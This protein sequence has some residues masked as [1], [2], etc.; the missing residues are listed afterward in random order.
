[1]KDNQI[2]NKLEVDIM[3]VLTRT[4]GTYHSQFKIYN[5]LVED[6]D[7]KDPV[8]KDNLKTKILTILRVLPHTFNNIKVIK[9][10]NIL[11][12]AFSPEKEIITNEIINEKNEELIIDNKWLSE[13]AVINFIIDE[14]MD[15]YIYKKDYTGNTVLHSLILSNDE[16]RIKKSFNKLKNM[17]YEKNLDKQTP[18]EVIN[19]FKVSNFFINY[20]FKEYDLLNKNFNVTKII[21]ERLENHLLRLY[22]ITFFLFC[23]LLFESLLIYNLILKNK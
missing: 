13:I 17:I 2:F 6:L 21:I 9:E 19:T 11:Y 14:N 18:I 23:M 7:M 15:D 1:M 3:K 4:S 8:E 10:N 12:V 22:T 5:E 20:L 16:I